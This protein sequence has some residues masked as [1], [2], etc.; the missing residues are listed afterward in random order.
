VLLSELARSLVVDRLP[1]GVTL[2]DLGRH[3]L[4][5][6][7]QPEHVFQVDIAGL[8][9]EFPALKSLDSRPHNLPLQPTPLIGR[10]S[11]VAAAR[12]LLEREHVRLLT[13][14]GPGGTG[15]TR[16]ALQIAAE[17]LDYYADGVY[18][19][20]LAAIDDPALV[21]PTIATALRL[22][23]TGSAAVLDLLRDRLRDQQLLLVL[24]NFE[25]VAAA[26]NVVSTLLG[27]CPRL[28]VLVTSRTRLNLYGEQEFP[29]PPLAL[30][31]AQHL[32]PLDELLGYDAVR[33]FVERAQAAKPGFALDKANAESIVEICRRLDGL[34][35][36]I[37]LAAA[38]IRLLPPAA[39]LARLDRSLPLLT[40]GARDLPAR[41]QTLRNAIAWS[42]DL[43]SPVEQ[44]AF[45][46]LSVFAGG[47]TL[48]SAGYVIEETPFGEIGFDTLERCAALVDHS[49]I[50]QQDADDTDPRFSMLQTIR[51]YS[52]ELLEADPEQPETQRRHATYFVA[53]AEQAEPE[54]EGSRQAAWL[55]RLETEHDNLRTAIAWSLA[56]DP[57]VAVRLGAA[58]RRFWEI[59][60]HLQE[61]RSQLETIT[62]AAPDEAS[63]TLARVLEGAG[64]LAHA[65]GDYPAAEASFERGLSVAQAVGDTE[66]IATINNGL[67]SVALNTGEFERALKYFEESV[68]LFQQMD[69]RRWAVGNALSSLAVAYGIR[70]DLEA[71]GRLLQEALDVHRALDNAWGIAVTLFNL[72]EVSSQLDD[73]E[74]AQ[75]Q[76]QESM[77]MYRTLGDVQ[78]IVECFGALADVAIT[79]GDAE[80]SARLYGIEDQQRELHR[81]PLAAINSD[82][83]EH[84]LSLTREQLGPERYAEAWSSG[85]AMPLDGAFEYALGKAMA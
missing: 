18:F 48:E 78:G 66:A 10:E 64:F 1:T 75:S 8:P 45:R 29:V 56:H 40:G 44:H 2:S 57:A 80:R 6:L 36:A 51:E 35:L 79:R 34:P 16:L 39:M 24:D 54:V 27:S 73:L 15:K 32:P 61:G 30:P 67:G 14:I 43:L 83:R 77:T 58:L 49:L 22:H 53:L 52:Q 69:V 38:R 70:G 11:E 17:M 71:A 3:R 85:H 25:Q 81:M 65:Q 19:V 74:N 12:E 63:A 28:N 37:E 13:L 20:P 46:Q 68:R 84:H 50:R 82:Q 7:N 60:G 59:R 41:Q 55:E 26:A 33:L 47:W 31:D 21:A 9:R 76:L 62:T 23:E 5:D 4:K 42:Y 72:A